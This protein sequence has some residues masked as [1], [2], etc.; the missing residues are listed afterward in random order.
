MD[1][2]V[3]STP[4]WTGEEINFVSVLGAF[5]LKRKFIV[6]NCVALGPSGWSR[7]FRASAA[8][9]PQ[10]SPFLLVSTAFP[11][12]LYHLSVFSLSYRTNRKYRTAQSICQLWAGWPSSQYVNC[13][14]DDPAVRVEPI[15]ARN[16]SSPYHTDQFW[17]PPSHPSNG[18]R[19]GGVKWPE[20]ETKKT[21]AHTSIPLTPSWHSA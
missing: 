4:Q 1:F 20:H 8:V 3:K 12:S 17:D 15:G 10:L 6:L 19:G 14:L 16:V 21:W 2:I 7:P 11:I 5:L 13:G 9:V 18:Y